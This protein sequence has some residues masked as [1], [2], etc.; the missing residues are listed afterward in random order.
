MSVNIILI[1]CFFIYGIDNTQ[2]YLSN[3]ILKLNQLTNNTCDHRAKKNLSM[4]YNRSERQQ[5]TGIGS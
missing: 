5:K 2:N 1:F 4:Q 3:L